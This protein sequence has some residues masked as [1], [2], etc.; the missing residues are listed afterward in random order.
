M[1]ALLHGARKS[2]CEKRVQ[3]HIAPILLIGD[4]EP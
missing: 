4:N 1:T 3:L 2:L